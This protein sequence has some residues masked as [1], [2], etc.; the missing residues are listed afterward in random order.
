MQ[1]WDLVL[2][3]PHVHSTM[4]CSKEINFG[5]IFGECF[6]VNGAKSN[7]PM[8]NYFI[9]INRNSVMIID[10]LYAYDNILVH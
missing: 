2:K 7:S 10:S 6:N 4:K 5:K 9:N 1:C 8:I 3:S